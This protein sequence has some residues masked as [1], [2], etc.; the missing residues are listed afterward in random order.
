M[1]KDI[2]LFLRRTGFVI[3][4]LLSIF[5][6]GYSSDN[7][8]PVPRILYVNSYHP[9][10]TWTDQ[11][12][13]GIFDTLGRAYGPH[14]DL[15]VEYLDAKRFGPGL[16]TDLAKEISD[17]WVK[18]YKGVKFDLILVSDQDGYDIIRKHR[19]E[20][21]PGVP[22]VFSGVEKP[23]PLDK[24]TTGVLACT[25]YLE[26]IKLILAV[27]PQVKRIWVITDC[28][29]TGK[30]NRKKLLEAVSGMKNVEIRFFDEGSGIEQDALLDKA[31]YLSPSDA[32]FLLDY[33]TTP[34]GQYVDFNH[35]VPLFTKASPAPVFTHVD[36][37]IGLGV[38]GG[39]MNSGYIQGA[40]AAELGLRVLK[41][42]PA[43]SIPPQFDRAIPIFNYQVLK[44]FGIPLNQLPGGSM[45][46]NPPDDFFTKYKYYIL[47]WISALFIEGALIFILF[48]LLKKQRRLKRD[49]QQN[50]AAF[51]A[52]VTSSPYCI[53][54]QKI[55]DFRFTMVNR[56]FEKLTG[57][58]ASE[59]IG[60]T[61]LELGIFKDSGMYVNTVTSHILAS[62]TIDDFSTDIVDRNGRTKHV[63]MSWCMID[64][65]N[66]HV[67]LTS[68][69]DATRRKEAEAALKES[70]EKHRI[71]FKE[72]PD[73]HMVLA[74]GIVTDCNQACEHMFKADRKWLIGKAP[75]EFSPEFQENG[76]KSE[77]AAKERIQSALTSGTKTFEWVHRKSD[78]TDFFTEVSLSSIVLNDKPTLFA[79]IRDITSRKKA[80][81]ENAKLQ[82]QLQ[83]AQKMEIV[84][85]LAGGVAH[86]FNNMLCVILGNAELAMKEAP[87]GQPIYYHLEEIWKAAEH[88]SELTT[89]LLAFARKQAVSPKLLNINAAVEGALKMIKRLIGENIELT[90][91]PG[92][93]IHMVMMDPAQI[94]QLLAN[95]TVNSRD[96]IKGVGNITIETENASFD[97]A[98]VK[99]HQDCQ[100]PGDYVML[101][102]SDTGC[103]IDD[104]VLP[105][106][107][108]PF[109]TT[110]NVGE[111]TGL[112]LATV[113]GIVRQNNGFI[114]VYSEVGKGTSFKIY[115]PAA[116]DQDI[117]VQESSPVSAEQHGGNE[118]IL[119]V[120]DEQSILDMTKK[121][122]ERLG[123]NVLTALSPKEAL[124]IA[125]QKGQKIDLLLTDVVMPEMNGRDLAKKLLIVAP[126]IKCLFMSGYTAN[127]ISGNGILEKGVH[128][129]QKPFSNVDL[130]RKVREALVDQPAEE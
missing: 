59:I 19:R 115:I 124:F 120:E 92:E 83:Q 34:G 28:S 33:Y 77:T 99:D 16:K 60:K 95:L 4:L 58:A 103:G 71:L 50:A 39:K 101:A 21:F 96:A 48:L 26:N 22:V 3:F 40:Q 113:Y 111:G 18:K 106:I 25:E 8:Q 67:V 121:I 64:Y 15:R 127:V 1:L 35:F 72:A 2:T 17:V 80:E 126:D 73:G 53:T 110:K 12:Q 105:Y 41:G 74:D 86:D 125:G 69:V 65:M 93:K 87:V 51:E 32:V 56:S 43:D 81:R 82:I 37:Y 119:I 36:M 24:N 94:D 130:A 114:N 11:V 44:R 84:G 55:P 63:L 100:I 109:F 57:M 14:I 78:G 49:A 102:V 75:H 30:I 76:E 29:T 47:L 6:V 7:K 107:F 79:S 20:L 89:Q 90:W 5:A 88:S 9:G 70:E 13:K 27:L 85:R 45:I 108:E 23:E 52:I 38:A 122:L 91:M 54:I 46:V 123:Y 116:P 62:K 129:I 128:F 104:S 61:P 98:Y 66:D 118:T 10:Y 112:G 97:A 68:Y 117:P 42:E 31:S